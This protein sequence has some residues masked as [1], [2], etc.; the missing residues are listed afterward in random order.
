MHLELASTP[1]EENGQATTLRISGLFSRL[2]SPS[3]SRGP[4]QK[5]TS[6]SMDR[7]L[8]LD[9]VIKLKFVCYIEQSSCH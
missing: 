8:E 5:V 7:D 1:N 4:L 3:V 9:Q 6:P 2:L